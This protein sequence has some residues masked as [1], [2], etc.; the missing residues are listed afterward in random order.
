MNLSTQNSIS[1]QLD[2]GQIT[3]HN[4]I[5]AKFDNK[6]LS[7]LDVVKKMDMIFNNDYPQFTHSKLARYQFYN[8]KWKDTLQ[9]M[10]DRELIL[11]DAK[12]IGIKIT[13]AETREELLHRY[14]PNIML[15]LD[16]L[17]LSYEEARKMVSEDL[18]V[19]RVLYFK[20]YSEAL[21]IRPEDIKKKY[22][23]YCKENT[24][25]QKWNYQVLSIKSE[26]EK[27]SQAI[28]QLAFDLLKEQRSLQDI[29]ADLKLKNPDTNI[30]FSP[31]IER[32]SL[33]ISEAHRQGIETLNP[34]DFSLPISQLNRDQSTV[35]RIFYLKDKHEVNP[36]EFPVLAEKIKD[37][38]IQECISSRLPIY[39]KKLK[40]RYSFSDQ[41]LSE[42]IFSDFKPFS[43]Q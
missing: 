23:A 40:K 22:T 25:S 42:L 32:D 1:S 33:S 29:T 3:I 9:K 19:E 8:A 30:I 16:K 15:S 36:P 18:L 37:R 24:A 28:A 41:E 38:L 5:L 21:H 27:A 39:I 14:G 6:T 26:D 20:V 17:Q 34:G 7:V 43:Y 4:R 12:R 2:N 35:Y 31:E 13:D 11:L 10:I